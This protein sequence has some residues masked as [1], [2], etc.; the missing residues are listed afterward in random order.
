MPTS[1]R[2]LRARAYAYLKSS[3]AVNKLA[4]ECDDA[5]DAEDFYKVAKS[6]WIEYG[7]YT[8]LA[9]QREQK[10]K[11]LEHRRNLKE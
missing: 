7:R 5:P 4:D 9:E 8:R 3:E 10:E 6:L 11:E 1:S 2:R